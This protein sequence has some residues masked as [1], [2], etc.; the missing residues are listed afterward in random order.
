MFSNSF[1][2]NSLPYNERFNVCDSFFM[3][4]GLSKKYKVLMNE[5]MKQKKEKTEFK[6]CCKS[7]E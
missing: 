1:L 6:I 4:H 3:P 5:A 7:L 2:I